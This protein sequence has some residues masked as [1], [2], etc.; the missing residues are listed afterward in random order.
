MATLSELLTN[1]PADRQPVAA[2]VA[3]LAAVAA[4]LSATIRR[5]DATAQLG[6]CLLYTSPSPRDS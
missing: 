1:M 5:A 4:D 2:A 3:A 6:A